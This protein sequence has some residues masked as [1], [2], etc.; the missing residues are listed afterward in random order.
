MPLKWLR[1]V[2]Y[3]AF[4][5]GMS[6]IAS[7]SRL[8]RRVEAPN[9]VRRLTYLHQL[10]VARGR[11]KAVIGDHDIE[12]GRFLSDRVRVLLYLMRL[13]DDMII[14]CGRRLVV[15]VELVT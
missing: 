4:V 2:R 7:C 5:S 10:L 6:T 1:V 9:C 13:L 12:A 3:L 8:G 14:I 15:V 11:L